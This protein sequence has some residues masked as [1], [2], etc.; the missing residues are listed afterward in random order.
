MANER[1]HSQSYDLEKQ[2]QASSSQHL[3][4]DQHDSDVEA[5]TANVEP[6]S[7]AKTKGSVFNAPPVKDLDP[8]GDRLAEDPTPLTPDEFYTLLGVYPPTSGK[9]TIG[10]L[11]KPHGF[12]SQIHKKMQYTTTKY[13]AFDFAAYVFLVLQLIISAV[14]IIL[15]SLTHVDTHL[16]IAILGA[17]ST[18]IA[19][20]LALMKGQGLPNRLRVARDELKMVLFG[21]EEL[22]WDI[23]SGREVLFKDIKK[24]REDYLRVMK[25]QEEAHP[26]SF[27][28][29]A[30]N[31][32]Q[33]VS[34][35]A[36]KKSGNVK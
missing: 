20:S 25:E 3:E 17:V 29:A 1:R 6:V 16:T 12:Y 13:R 18:V 19:G 4:D 21:A 35:A 10:Q 28:G 14:F 34:R 8:A 9:E 5:V 15:G 33:G 26:D 23:R 27:G 36:P 11:A 31:M 2:D 32:A 24:I 30:K 22:Y 7:P